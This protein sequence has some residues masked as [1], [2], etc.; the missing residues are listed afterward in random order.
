LQKQPARGIGIHD[1]P[2]FYSYVTDK[3]HQISIKCKF[4]KL[5]SEFLMEDWVLK[6]LQLDLG[7]LDTYSWISALSNWS[8]ADPEDRNIYQNMR[9]ILDKKY[10]LDFEFSERDITFFMTVNETH[11]ECLITKGKWH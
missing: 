8:E 1:L 11:C 9:A 2:Q 4:E 5:S 7:P 6:N 3:I 10:K